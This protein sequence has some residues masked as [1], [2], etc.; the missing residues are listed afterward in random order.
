MRMVEA[1]APESKNSTTTTVKPLVIDLFMYNG[2]PMGLYRMMYLQDYV[3][4]FIVVESLE[5]HQLVTN[6]KETYFID[7]A[8]PILEKLR[9]EGKLEVLRIDSV[10]MDTF[11]LSKLNPKKP[12]MVRNEVREK[13]WHREIYMRNIGLEMVYK[14]ANQAPFI[15]IHGDAD[16]LPKQHV[17]EKFRD[18][19]DYIDDGK[20]LEMTQHIYNFKFLKEKKKVNKKENKSPIMWDHAFVITDKGIISANATLNEMRLLPKFIESMEKIHGAGWHCSWCSGADGIIR[21]M[22]SFSHTERNKDR[23]KKKDVIEGKL[24]DGIALFS[25]DKLPINSCRDG[26]DSPYDNKVSTR[27]FPFLFVNHCAPRK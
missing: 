12:K 3:D 15:L 11:E 19:Y 4:K 17:V 13:A 24:R 16:E 9:M 2:E 1:F 21:K 6:P 7:A 27:E 25:D 20:R 8:E 26:L 10:P 5:T 18:H 23:F 14:V 22:E